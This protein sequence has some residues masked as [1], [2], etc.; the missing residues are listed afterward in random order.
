M[1]QKRFE[2]QRREF[3]MKEGI[4]VF[5]KDKITNGINIKNVLDIINSYIPN[6]FLGEIDS[7]Y[8]GIFDDFIKKDVNAAYKDGAIYISNEQQNE[9]DLI[10]DIVHE[11]AH[12]LE[13]PYGHIIYGDKKIE[14]EFS[15]KRKKLYEILESEGLNPDLD[16][17]LDLEYNPKMDKYLYKEVGYDRLNF[18]A[19]SYNLFTSAY[20]ATSLREYFASGFEYYFLEDPTHLM[21]VSPQL[22]KKIEELH[23]NGSE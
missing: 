14:N 2:N 7:I 5:I 16:L 19:A 8:V 3:L 23:E 22:Y 11:V 10:D 12:S 4:Q 1:S 20:P 18:I 21:K 6:T 17:F 9:Q 13:Q 15:E